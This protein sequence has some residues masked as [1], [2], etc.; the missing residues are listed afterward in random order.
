MGPFCAQPNCSSY[1]GSDVVGGSE[2][3]S[4][5]ADKRAKKGTKNCCAAGGPNNVNCSNKTGTPGIAM[6][7]FPKE[8]SLRQ[9]WTRFVRINRR[10]FVPKK[11][12]CLCSAHFD[13]CC[14][15][16]KPLSLMDATGEAIKRLIKGSVPTRTDVVPYT[17]PLTDRKRRREPEKEME[18]ELFAVE[19]EEEMEEE[20]DEE[21]KED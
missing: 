7:Y 5:M 20:M 19:M 14:F 17:S 1:T 8:E 10:D 13:D 11:S 2:D 6:P 16:R 9:K 21:V 4:V 12:S 18:G 15:E 3:D